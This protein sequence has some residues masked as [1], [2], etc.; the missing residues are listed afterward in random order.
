MAS[1]DSRYT[2][3]VM[4]VTSEEVE[5]QSQVPKMAEVIV[6][7][8]SLKYEDMQALEVLLTDAIGNVLKGLGGAIAE[9]IKG[10]RVGQTK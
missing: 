2:L 3:Q 10:K 4:M 5:G 9:E 1:V 6:N 8:Y 7:Q